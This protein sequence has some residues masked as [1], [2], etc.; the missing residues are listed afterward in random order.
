MAWATVLVFAV[1][2]SRPLWMTTHTTPDDFQVNVV[3]YWQASQGLPVDGTR[4]Y[5][6]STITWVSFYLTWP[7]VALGIAGLA[8]GAL[9]LGRGRS[10]WAIPLA[11]LLV[12]AML[13]VV[14][15]AIMPDQVWAIRRLYPSLVI[16]LLLFAAVAWQAILPRWAA[17][18]NAG[19]DWPGF[20]SIAIAA[21]IAG[22]P[23]TSWISVTQPTGWT[24][25]GNS[26]LYLAE[27]R[28]AREQ[29][30]TLC[31]YVDGRPV[32][33]AGT[34]SHLGTLRV[35]CDVPVVLSLDALSQADVKQIADALGEEP[36]VLTR[37]LDQVP[38]SE[39]P[40]APTFLSRTRYTGS[41]LSGLPP[42]PAPQEFDWYVGEARP[43]GSVEFVPG[44]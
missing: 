3:A 23:L 28:G 31:E 38:W 36:V 17:A 27:Q 26:A 2:A 43:D 32:L 24:L 16:G 9:R 41:S 1:L 12:P 7:V 44:R 8:I 37:T 35:A 10:L 34:S 15:P 13:Y 40:D 18:R 4:T 30:D 29:V 33:L 11:G 21:V 6:E 25:S 19:R 20:A 5:A 42:Y 14:R 22:A 39:E